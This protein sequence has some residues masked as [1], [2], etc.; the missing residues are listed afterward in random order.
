[1]LENDKSVIDYRQNVNV[2]RALANGDGDESKSISYNRLIKR[3]FAIMPIDRII[4]IGYGSTIDVSNA[5]HAGRLKS[6]TVRRANRL[7]VGDDRLVAR[8]VR[9]RF[10][11][12]RVL[13]RG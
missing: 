12:L 2:A 3:V 13:T 9:Y 6:Q 4:G 7:S 11:V 10:A 8:Q 5:R 1:M